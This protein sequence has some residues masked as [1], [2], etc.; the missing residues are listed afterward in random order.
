[1]QVAAHRDASPGTWIKAVILCIARRTMLFEGSDDPG[2][3]GRY[4]ASV[5]DKPE[6]S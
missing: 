3:T 6:S 1:M 5:Y 4:Y 2:M